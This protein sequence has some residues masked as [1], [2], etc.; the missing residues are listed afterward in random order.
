MRTL[1]GGQAKW[2]R[3][4]AQADAGA[5]GGASAVAYRQADNFI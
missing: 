5:S 2:V 1:H 4:R 3:L